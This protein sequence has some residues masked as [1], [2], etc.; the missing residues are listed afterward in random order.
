M[1]A[2]KTIP[3][4]QAAQGSDTGAVT[5]TCLGSSSAGNGYI[6]AARDGVLLL[7]AGIRFA[8]VKEALGWDISRVCGCL[9]THRHGDHA[10]HL[11]ETAKAGIRIL[12]P[13]DTVSRLKPLDR[14]FATAT[15]PMHGYRLGSF[16]AFAFPLRHADSD[17]TPCPC[18]GWVIDHPDMG[19]LLFAT[20]TMAIAHDFPGVTHAMIEA[21]Y[22]DPLLESAIAEGVTDPSQ[23]SRL[24]ASHLALHQTAAILRRPG[25]AA[26]QQTVLLHLSSRN[27]DP[28]QFR[29]EIEQ[30]TGRPAYVAAPGLKVTFSK[31]PY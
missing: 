19:R 1:T 21:N 5:M 13:E 10:A 20:D 23:K 24:L 27:S 31:E 6:L 22:S 29:R 4:P 3:T 17:G 18:L 8:R 15:L 9:V 11:H 7:E 2:T 25:F 30:S 12:A 16:K 28:E 26:L 14:I